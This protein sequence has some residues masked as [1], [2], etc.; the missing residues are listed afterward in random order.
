MNLWSE[1][2]TQ[3]AQDK[4]WEAKVKRSGGFVGAK[5]Y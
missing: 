5:A 4:C 3:K 2:Q 1:S